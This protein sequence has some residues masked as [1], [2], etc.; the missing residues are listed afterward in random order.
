MS[1]DTKT[2]NLQ[3]L[4]KEDNSSYVWKFIGDPRSSKVIAGFIAPAFGC[5][6][7][8]ITTRIMPRL[9]YLQEKLGICIAY[10]Q[11]SDEALIVENKST[12]NF[13]REAGIK[14]IS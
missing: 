8:I 6:Q 3:F 7:A 5:S 14:S 2:E 4:K 11:Y 9:R 12:K 1:K 10:P 13:F